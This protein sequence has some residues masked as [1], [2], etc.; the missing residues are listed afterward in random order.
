[1]GILLYWHPGP[2]RTFGSDLATDVGLGDTALRQ[3]HT[4]IMSE[5]NQ[6]FNTRWKHPELFDKGYLPIPAR[7]LRHYAKLDPKITPREAMFV[8][9]LMEF[10]WD[11]ALPFPTYKTLARRM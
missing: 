5:A 8:L 1:M 10:K 3:T 4:L 6:S 7:F 2:N 11:E 9:H